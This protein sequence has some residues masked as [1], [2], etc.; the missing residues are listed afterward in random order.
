MSKHRI[1]LVITLLLVF[2]C[3]C[4][5]QKAGFN[6]GEPDKIEKN[7]QSSRKSKGT[8]KKKAHRES[9][10]SSVP[11]EN[12]GDFV[13]A[14]DYIPN[15]TTDLKYA[16]ENNFTGTVIYRFDSAYL[17][18]GTA[19][20][21]ADVSKEVARD[22]YALM[23]WDAYR[24]IDA[25]FKLWEV[26]PNP[27]YVANPE[28]GYS[29]HSRGNTVDITLVGL[30]GSSIEMPTDFDDFTAKAD[31]DYSDCSQTEAQNAMY[32]ENMMTKHGF[33]AYQG[34]WWHYTDV[35]DY[36]VEEEFMPD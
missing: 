27:Q 28:S 32:L 31:R 1:I 17:R 15:I 29:S 16:T 7:K 9:E 8:A 6:P 2:V 4:D 19:K 18:Y 36:P 14:E 35:D 21:L 3:A 30:D 23:I 34:E 11:P 20:K 12:D 22:G 13:L 33:R 5:S 26:C 10:S 25:Q 24:P